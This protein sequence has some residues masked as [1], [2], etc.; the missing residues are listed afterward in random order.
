MLGTDLQL[1]PRIIVS[2]GD[3]LVPAGQVSF[4]S[5]AP[6]TVSVDASGRITGLATGASTILAS[7]VYETQALVDTL[8]V[9]VTLF[10]RAQ[11]NGDPG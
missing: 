5:R 1:A 9:Q 7:T 4:T 6:A 11:R 10:G 8:A 3:T 2:T